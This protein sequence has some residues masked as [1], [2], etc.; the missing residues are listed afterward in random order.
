MNDVAS[1]TVL[2]RSAMLAD[3][4]S[5]ALF[6]LGPDKGRAFLVEHQSALCGDGEV[7]VLWILR[8]GRTVSVDPSR[9]FNL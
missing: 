7:A 4:L 8:D 2:C 1:V 3:G 6:V 9:R 5:T